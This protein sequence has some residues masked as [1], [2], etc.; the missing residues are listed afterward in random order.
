MVLPVVCSSHCEQRW[1]SVLAKLA[2]L[3]NRL[4]L[5]NLKLQESATGKDL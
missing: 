4:E 5:T 2:E 1:K 3:E